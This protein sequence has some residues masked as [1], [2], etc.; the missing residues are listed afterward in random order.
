MVRIVNSLPMER[1][2]RSRWLQNT[3][4]LPVAGVSRFMH[5]KCVTN[6]TRHVTYSDNDYVT[7]RVDDMID[8]ICVSYIPR[9]QQ[10]RRSNIYD[11]VLDDDDDVDDED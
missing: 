6:P 8:E 3:V 4:Q 9:R 5:A 11:D 2:L 10:L 1:G 7:C